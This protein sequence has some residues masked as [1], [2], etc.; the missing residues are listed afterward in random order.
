LIVSPFGVFFGVVE[1]RRSKLQAK[2]ETM[3]ETMTG[4]EVAAAARMDVKAFKKMASPKKPTRQPDKTY[5]RVDVEAWLSK[6]LG[7]TAIVVAQPKV[8]ILPPIIK[9]P[10]Q[11]G[12]GRLVDGEDEHVLNE[13]LR[14]RDVNVQVLDK[15]IQDMTIELVDL[16]KLISRRKKSLAEYRRT[17]DALR[18]DAELVSRDLDEEHIQTLLEVEEEMRRG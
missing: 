10:A 12:R 7:R 5:L 8:E 11:D 1:I 4:E 18:H 9:I 3:D 6:R 16:E 15:V 17:R 13:R 2:G 14:G